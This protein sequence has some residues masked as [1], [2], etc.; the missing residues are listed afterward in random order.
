MLLSSLTLPPPPP[1]PD[2]LQVPE[3]AEVHEELLDP[4]VPADPRGAPEAVLASGEV[5]RKAQHDGGLLGERT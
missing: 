2:V 4:E 1:S 5:P 3:T